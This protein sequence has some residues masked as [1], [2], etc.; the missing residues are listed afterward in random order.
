M[1]G[2]LEQLL[3]Q[4]GDD[5]PAA[6]LGSVMGK[7]PAWRSPLAFLG[8]APRQQPSIMEQARR[9][10]D[11]W[12]LP[13]QIEMALAMATGP[14]A[15]LPPALAAIPNARLP[16]GPAEFVPPP[17]APTAPPPTVARGPTAAETAAARDDWLATVRPGEY[18]TPRRPEGLS[19]SNNL[20][21][22]GSGPFSYGIFK[23][24]NLVGFMHGGVRDGR[25]FVSNIQAGAN[26][27]G[28]PGLKRLRE[29]FR[30]D[31]PGVVDFY[32]TR[33]TG[34]RVKDP[35]KGTAPQ[36]VRI[37]SAVLPIGV[38]GLSGLLNK[39]YGDGPASP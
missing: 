5:V 6:D 18:G 12:R 17:R 7:Q 3:A 19:L 32:G 37:P 30:Q 25:A 24:G 1:A 14:R 28:I 27:F 23:D 4:Y 33:Y 26:E 38:G 16:L 11:Y 20:R 10:D 36:S 22:E 34:A 9:S 8:S 29:D 31:F 39:L 21:S 2:E 35:A 13:S 15:N